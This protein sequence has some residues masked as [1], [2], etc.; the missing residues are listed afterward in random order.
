MPITS[1]FWSGNTG[2]DIHVLRGG[3]TRDLTH[4]SLAFT[5]TDGTTQ[6]ADEY[7]VQ[8][9]DVTLTFTPVFRGNQQ[10]TDF[11]GDNNGIRVNT[12]IG[13][14]SVDAA[15]PANVKNNFIIEVTATND[16]DHTAFHETIRV[17]IHGSVNQVWLT[18]DLLT[19]RPVGALPETSNYRFSVRAQF[20]DGIVGDLTD[21][22]GVTWQPADR[23]DDE[24]KLRLLAGDNV[25]NSI[26]MNAT[27]P[28]EFGG[29]S[30][31]VGPTLR[32]G[33][34]WSDEPSPPRLSIVAGGALPAT[35]LAEN[36]PNVL[37]L[38]DGFRAE[39]EPS[40]N[41]IVDTFV[42]H[43]KNNQLMRPYN[44][45]SGSMNFWRAFAAADQL[46][47]SYRSE[48]YL[49]GINP[50]ARPIPAV[51]KPP[52]AGQWKLEHL[53]YQVGLPVPSDAADARTVA[54]LKAEW[55]RL[56]Q[57]DPA[58]NVSDDLVLRW[59]ALAK[60]TFLEEHDSF[61]GMQYGEPPAANQEDTLQLN[62][63]EDR[64][65]TAGLTPFYRVLGSDDVALA[66][67]RPVGVLWAEKTFRF[68]NTDLVVLIS[69][70]PGGRALNGTGFIAVSTLGGNV[71][72]PVKAVPGKNAFTFDFTTIPTD[73][74]ADRSR[75]IAHEL[76]HSFGLGD[77]YADF[78]RTFPNPHADASDAN[79]ESL[80]DTQIPDPN[81]PANHI[82]SGDQI[83][84][85]WHRITA[86][87]VVEGNIT[88]IGLD[89][90][91]I[92]VIPD[93]SFRFK[94][95]DQLI[96]RPRTWG[97]PL[98]KFDPTEISG[99]LI[100]TDP[101]E[102]D[103]LLVR[104]TTTAISAQRYPSGSLIYIPKPAPASVLSVAY[105]YAE[106]V[107]KNVKDAITTN[108]K[109]LTVIPCVLDQNDTQT[110]I[111]DNTEGRTPVANIPASLA[112]MTRIVGLYAGGALSSCGIFH[113]TGQCM[114]RQDHE[115]HA[116]FC[117]VCRYIMVDFINPA[118]HPD[119][120]AFYDV[121]YP[122]R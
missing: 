76:G 113:P 15:I 31:P 99:T 9:A 75:T 90:F 100:V 69:P 63:H 7:L 55:A 80:A 118:F 72:I 1:I 68:D 62:I 98:R 111:L 49:S 97:Q 24:G 103:A 45:L 66:D 95:G 56:L 11:V 87:A 86:A 84:W 78:D 73:V 65:G 2:R 33:Q 54:V 107:A 14:V 3:S 13:S 10:G 5:K 28:A 85:V 64:A 42:H 57:V 94:Q 52:A 121:I 71:Y 37:F 39:D 36:S 79:L 41:Q 38:G 25:G 19:V 105:P 82:I 48:M 4:E 70:L 88:A 23:V 101:P 18:P 43:L 21:N 116:E 8:V 50:Y 29:A 110:P 81:N 93:V 40:F 119:I 114:M 102:S 59:K 112:D 53:L 96:L 83:S 89:T 17:Q 91:R 30:T 60:R 117:A 92:P 47:I 46:G 26:F 61:P 120:D 12:G 74:E 104:S 44:F 32:I 67:A 34:R 20:D 35:G 109:P 115:A 22:H 6:F 16:G 106:M 108:R 51:E 122:L 27:L 58:P 77:E